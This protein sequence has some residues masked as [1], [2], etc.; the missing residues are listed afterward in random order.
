MILITIKKIS[1]DF[2]QKHDENHVKKRIIFKISK[3]PFPQHIMVMFIKYEKM[4]EMRYKGIELANIRKI[5]VTE[6]I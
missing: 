6:I 3:S 4:R 5:S 1:R 2:F